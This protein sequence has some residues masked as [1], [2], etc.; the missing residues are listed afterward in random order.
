MQRKHDN[1]SEKQDTKKRRTDNEIQNDER[2][3]ADAEE[4]R[5]LEGGGGTRADGGNA[6][7]GAGSMPAHRSITRLGGGGAD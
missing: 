2:K 4:F 7:G 1:K 3:Q 5:A 6:S